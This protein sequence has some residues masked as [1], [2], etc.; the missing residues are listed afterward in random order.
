LGPVTAGREVNIALRDLHLPCSET[1]PY[2]LRRLRDQLETNLSA[3]LGPS[4]AHQLMAD[5]LPYKPQQGA[6][7]ED[8]RFIESRLEQ[9]RDRLSGL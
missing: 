7:G 2:A 8:I 5:N 4:V 3:L 9:Y 6:S 1:R